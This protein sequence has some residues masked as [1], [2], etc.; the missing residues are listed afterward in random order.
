[1]NELDYETNLEIRANLFKALGHPTRLLIVN[2]VKIKPR[3]GEELA[4]ILRLNPGTISHHLKQLTEAGFLSARKDQYYQIYTLNSAL[5]DCKMADLVHLAQPD[6]D[7]GAEVNAYRQKVLRTFFKHGRL[8]QFPAQLKKRLVILEKIAE[9][10]EPGREYSEREVNHIL[11]D[12]NDDVATLR[13]GMI[14]HNIMTRDK[15]IYRKVSG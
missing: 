10:F 13:R 8:V 12:F 4:E 14:E 7:S 2:L 3:H 6:L 9:E 1:M 11:L 5:L 15:G